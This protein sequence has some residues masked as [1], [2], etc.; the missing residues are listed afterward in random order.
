MKDFSR[1]QSRAVFGVRPA[2]PD[3]VDDGVE[4]FSARHSRMIS[5]FIKFCCS[6]LVAFLLLSTVSFFTLR[7]TLKEI[8]LDTRQQWEGMLAL[9]RER[10][11]LLPGMVE[12]LKGVGLIQSRLGEKML[13][14]RS[15]LSKTTGPETI[16]RSIEETDQM[17]AKISQIA[18]SSGELKN[19]N[20][21]QQQW[22]RINYLNQELKLRR[23][24]Y[25]ETSKLY[26]SLLTSFPQNM[27]AAVFGFVPLNKFPPNTA[28]RHATL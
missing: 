23:A 3:P 27:I 10:N 22:S 8:H 18:T 26:N 19:N 12:T 20:L 21:F 5:G 2:V 17:L 24:G 1:Y 16:L 28:P 14:E 25:N 6:I 4:H 7:P 9:A 13:E 11:D 15:I